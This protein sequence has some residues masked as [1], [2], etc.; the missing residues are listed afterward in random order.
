ME[1]E[2]IW[3]AEN[4]SKYSGK[5]IALEGGR[6]LAVADS[7]KEVFSKVANHPTPPLVIR[8]SEHDLPFSGWSCIL[9]PSG[10]FTTTRP[11]QP[12]LRFRS[13]LA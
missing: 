3:L 10:P 5:W 6:L 1:K 2:R 8:I 4:R 9:S 13:P 11:P 12:E 7:A